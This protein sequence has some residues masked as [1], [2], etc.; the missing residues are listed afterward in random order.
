MPAQQSAFCWFAAAPVCW[1]PKRC[2]HCF[3]CLDVGTLHELNAVGD[4]PEHFVKSLP[5]GL[6]LAWQVDYQGLA[7]HTYIGNMHTQ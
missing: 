3:V 6:G 4:G 5:D 7:T 1:R 2:H